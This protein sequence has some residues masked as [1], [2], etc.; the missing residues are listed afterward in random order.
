[1][2]AARPRRTRLPGLTQMAYP[3]DRL[4]VE[5]AR[6]R[7]Q[8]F[9][10]GDLAI[11]TSLY[12]A[13][14]VMSVRRLGVLNDAQCADAL[15]SICGHW[16]THGCG[17]FA[18]FEAASGN[19]AGECGL[20][21][22]E[23]H[24]HGGEGG[25]ELSYGILPAFQGRGFATE[26]S[27]AVLRFAEERMGLRQLVGDALKSNLGSH[28][29]LR[30]CGFQIISEWEEDG[31]TGLRFAR[32]SPPFTALVRTAYTNAYPD[33][34]RL[35]TGQTV[36]VG[37]RDTEFPGWIWTQPSTGDAGWAPTVYLAISGG[38][39]TVLQDYAAIEL[40]LTAGE[41]V[42]V[43]RLL[44]SWAWIRKGSDGEGWV[45]DSHIAQLPNG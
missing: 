36:S 7:L 30:K 15:Q 26:A 4:I 2:E 24:E 29:V 28:R 35:T 37:R 40:D 41:T 3:D 31:V 17:M 42:T 20:R 45:P 10:H 22:L 32:H 21:H 38:H 23:A 39:A 27:L 19:F 44:G 18:V 12:S 5:T 33:P 11:L 13:P 34:I 16:R 14:Q 1:M 8:P 6:L 43:L 9:N 25:V